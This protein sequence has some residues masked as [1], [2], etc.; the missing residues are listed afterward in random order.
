MKILFVTFALLLHTTSVFADCPSCVGQDA[1]FD[2]CER[3]AECG[4][5]GVWL[6]EM[7]PLFRP[8]VAD[9]RQLTYSVG[10][11]FDDNAL[12][13]NII[14]ISFWDTFPIYRWCCLK[15][16][17]FCGQMQLSL[18]GGLWAVFDPC[19][20]SAPLINADY[21]V[22]G[23]LSYAF[24]AW[25]FRLR[26]FHISS[27]IGDEFLLNHP[28]FDRKNPSAETIDLFASHHLTDEI[29]I[30]AGA[31]IVVNHDDSYDCG[32]YNIEA[33]AEVRLDGLGFYSVSDAI[34]GRPYYGMHFR[35]ND[36]FCRHID[37][38]YVLGYEFAKLTGLQR[39][40]RAWVEYHDGYSAEGQFSCR[41]TNYV[42]LRLSY[43][44]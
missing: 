33:G 43:G 16:G 15:I 25:Q 13:H 37:Q 8:F 23:H 44:Y 11:R 35:Y 27:H 22:G 29:R 7:P 36:K 38:T 31:G 39:R 34:C 9:P 10:W 28:N 3:A 2:D 5:R 30:Y 26:Y 41:G 4:K 17:P 12:S 1:C 24:G 21:Y 6:P 18:D 32:H 19:T 42:S 40:V 20:Y 14:P